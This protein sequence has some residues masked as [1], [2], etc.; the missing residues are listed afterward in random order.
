MLTRKSTIIRFHRV[1][2]VG[3]L[4]GVR[5]LLQTPTDKRDVRLT[6]YHVCMSIQYFQF[7]KDV[8]YVVVPRVCAIYETYAM[9]TDSS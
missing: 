2:R 5:Y 8:H 3:D 9:N 1:P 6:N 4:P 7:K